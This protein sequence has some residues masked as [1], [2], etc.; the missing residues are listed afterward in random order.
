MSDDKIAWKVVRWQISTSKWVSAK[1]QGRYCVAYDKGTMVTAMEG[2]LGI[3]CYL[4]KPAAQSFADRCWSSGD[5][6]IIQVRGEG[7]AL[8]QDREIAQ[9][10]NEDAL[11]LFYGKL[12]T[13]TVESLPH[14]VCYSAVTVL[15]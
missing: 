4:S 7:E 14:T 1:V 3:F 9:F 15:G 8:S 2:T 11:R 10:L 12:R 5:C 13:S 6:R